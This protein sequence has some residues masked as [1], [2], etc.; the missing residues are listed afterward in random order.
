MVRYRTIQLR[1]ALDREEGRGD[2]AADG[3]DEL[4]DVVHRDLEAEDRLQR[5]VVLDLLDEV[6]LEPLRVLHRG[7]RVPGEGRERHGVVDLHWSG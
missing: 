4:A 6:R 7:V 5:V 2:P 3:H 1:L